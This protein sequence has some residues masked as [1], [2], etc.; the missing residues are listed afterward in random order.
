MFTQTQLDVM[1]R[2]QDELNSKINSA[3]KDEKE[4][5]FM[6]A[7]ALEM[8]EAIEHYGWKWWKK[9][10]PDLNQVRM[11]LVDVWHFV[12]SDILRAAHQD[13]TPFKHYL[14]LEDFDQV[15]ELKTVPA[16]KWLMGTLCDNYF[17][18]SVF[19]T[20]CGHVGLSGEQ[21]FKL[22][23]GKNVL[24]TF[25]QNN[26]YKDGT[27]IKVWSGREDNEYLTDILTTINLESPTIDNDLYE[28]LTAAYHLHA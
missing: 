15:Y 11:E 20:I 8:G 4:A 13:K 17:L 10:T 21:L 6:L 16:M 27:Y 22:Y 2:M 1:I 25:R 26:G 19:R 24:N 3:W 12:L 23:I 18:P 28:A 14:V 9:Q 7:A 5:D